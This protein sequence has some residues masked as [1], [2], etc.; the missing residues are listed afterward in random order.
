MQVARI[1]ALTLVMGEIAA[2]AMVAAYL[3]KAKTLAYPAAV[4]LFG[5]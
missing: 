3:R 5:L 4:P 1:L 2:A